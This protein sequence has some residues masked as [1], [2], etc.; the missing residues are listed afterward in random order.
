MG[1]IEHSTLCDRAADDRIQ[2]ITKKTWLNLTKSYVTSFHRI[3]FIH[4]NFI[5]AVLALCIV[6]TIWMLLN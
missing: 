5:D 3:M 1:T 4:D 6:L 2:A